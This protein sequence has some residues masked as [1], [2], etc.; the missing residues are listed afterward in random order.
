M[1]DLFFLGSL[2]SLSSRQT[3]AGSCFDR[4]MVAIMSEAPPSPAEQQE[5]QLRTLVSEWRP[6]WRPGPLLAVL[7]FLTG[8]A[9]LAGYCSTLSVVT[10]VAACELCLVGIGSYFFR[11]PALIS[12]AP[13]RLLSLL[14]KP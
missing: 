8:I 2:F 4:N 1:G 10:V 7:M 11:V 13:S 14:Q 3:T 9:M 6:M 12:V 5:S